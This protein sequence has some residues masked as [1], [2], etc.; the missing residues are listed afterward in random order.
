MGAA[1][2][3]LAVRC[4]VRRFLGCV[5]LV[6]ACRPLPTTA[7]AGE[8]D[9]APSTPHAETDTAQ[10]PAALAPR[11]PDA[12]AT[13]EPDAMVT[14]DPEAPRT[15]PVTVPQPKPGREPDAAPRDPTAPVAF[16]RGAWPHW[17]DAD[18]DCQDTRTEVLVAESEIPVEFTDRRRC[19][20]AK[21]RWRC[22]YTDRTVTDPR[23][24]DVDHLVPLAHAHAAGASTW[25]RE[26]RDAFANDLSDPD[27]LVA[28]MAAANRSKGARTVVQ[29]LPSE[30]GFRCEYIAAWRRIKRRWALAEL[31]DERAAIDDALRLCAA[32]DVPELPDAAGRSPK[33]QDAAQDPGPTAAP[34]GK[35]PAQCC[36]VCKA[37]KPCGDA[38]ISASRTCHQPPGCAC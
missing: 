9:P 12:T 23:Q 25:A 29:W 36:R 38:C 3:R 22:P 27:H 17:V 21:G 35:S 2:S 33:S 26:R 10:S 7:P 18:G 15:P 24:L 13:R 31:D 19:V 8:T 5:L 4:R 34:R 32:K 11:E 30:P 14:R 1:G 16:D 6:I 20:V 37:G 28:V